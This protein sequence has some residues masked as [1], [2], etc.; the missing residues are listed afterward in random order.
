M[1]VVRGH[2]NYLENNAQFLFAV[3]INWIVSRCLCC[4]KFRFIRKSAGV[5]ELFDLLCVLG[6]RRSRSLVVYVL[7]TFVSHLLVTF[8]PQTHSATRSRQRCAVRSFS[9]SRW[10][11]WRCTAHSSSTSPTRSACWRRLV[12]RNKVHKRIDSSFI[13]NF[14]RPDD[15]T[16]S[17]NQHCLL[18][19]N[20]SKR[21]R[22]TKKQ[23]ANVNHLKI[24]IS[25]IEFDTASA[26]SLRTQ[27]VTQCCATERRQS[28]FTWYQR[29]IVF[30]T[31]HEMFRLLLEIVLCE[32][33]DD[34]QI[35]VRKKRKKN[36][37][38]T[39]LSQRNKQNGECN[40]SH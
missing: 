35:T 34:W 33:I 14:V 21:S 2:E 7:I 26:E 5:E 19:R 8:V 38:T 22:K 9:S 16:S 10:R 4:S 29:W 13:W 23:A 27:W 32:Q 6:H 36:T 30:Y 25:E 1:S 18:V 39:F 11:R 28:D 3:L 31:L 40:W 15:A 20:V 24:W 17:S 37:Q 12:F